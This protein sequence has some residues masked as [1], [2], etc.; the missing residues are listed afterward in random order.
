MQ[1]LFL[2]AMTALTSTSHFQPP[3][4][5]KESCIGVSQ[6]LEVAQGCM[7]QGDAYESLP[8]LEAFVCP[9]VKEDSF[10]YQAAGQ[11]IE[12]QFNDLKAYIGE[13][14]SAMYEVLACA[15]M[16]ELDFQQ[17]A[18]YLDRADEVRGMK[19]GLNLATND[20]IYE[21]GLIFY[22]QQS[23]D[24]AILY[25]RK[26][27]TML[28]YA[29]RREYIR[30]GEAVTY[31]ALSYL[32]KGDRQ[33]A[34]DYYRKIPCKKVGNSVEGARYHY[35]VGLLLAEHFGLA[36]AEAH[37]EAAL[38]KSEV[39]GGMYQETAEFFCALGPRYMF[40]RDKKIVARFHGYLIRGLPLF[41]NFNRTAAAYGYR[42][43]TESY[44]FIEGFSQQVRDDPEWLAD[45][46]R[47][48]A[49]EWIHYFQKGSS[50]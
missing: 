8:R 48:A 3:M 22:R 42:L 10:G 1:S 49:K 2:F 17:E 23:Y 44:P 30:V 19:G 25:L 16:Q 47:T 6:P 14:L 21:L 4:V 50:L 34:R 26:T 39:L 33:G 35:R 18:F 13:D 28:Q 43:L 12:N 31:L 11:L 46:E 7:A 27:H 45:K 15:A 32:G 41:E 38:A 40:E 20:F 37:I 5:P 24:K 36:A 29:Y 9:P